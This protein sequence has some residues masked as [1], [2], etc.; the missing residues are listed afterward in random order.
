MTKDGSVATRTRPS[1]DTEIVGATSRAQ[2]GVERADGLI[3][4]LFDLLID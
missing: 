3:A 1:E 4:W 2:R